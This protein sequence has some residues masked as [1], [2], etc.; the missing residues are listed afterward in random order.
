MAGFTEVVI[1]SALSHGGCYYLPY[2]LHGTATQFDRAYPMS[3][4]FFEA[5][6]RYDPEERFINR[7]YLR[8][9]RN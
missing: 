6:R 2:R 9:G 3:Q 4:A 1:D 8:Y 7:F 5:N